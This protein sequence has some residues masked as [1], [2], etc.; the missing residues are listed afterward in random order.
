MDWSDRLVEIKMQKFKI[1]N[2]FT[3]IEL[4]L[5]MGIFSVLVA[6]STISLVNI[7]HKTSLSANVS[8]FNADLK[9]QQLKAMVGEGDSATTTIYKR[10]IY[11]QASNY[12][13]FRGSSYVAGDANN[14]SV[15]LSPNTQFTAPNTSIIF[16]KG[17]GDVTGGAT[18]IVLRDTL[19][20]SQKTIS[21]N[22]YGV[23]TGIN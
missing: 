4:I 11:M 7:Q 3:L 10:G 22:K 6:I 23:V 20:N 1:S 8:I 13:L 19:D 15:S 14:F 21:V 12:T 18:A 9:Q 5:V 2:G 17:S 16:E